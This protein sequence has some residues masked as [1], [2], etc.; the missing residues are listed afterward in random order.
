MIGDLSV[1]QDR[2]KRFNAHIDRTKS[3]KNSVQ[4]THRQTRKDKPRKLNVDMIEKTFYIYP[5]LL[6]NID[7]CL[8]QGA[9]I[10]VLVHSCHNIMFESQFMIKLI[11]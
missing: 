7:N 11:K 1:V 5:K 3:N 10:I 9:N 2:C 8:S 6:H 4:D